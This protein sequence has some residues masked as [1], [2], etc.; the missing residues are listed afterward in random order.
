MQTSNWVSKNS[1]TKDAFANPKVQKAIFSNDTIK[2]NNN[3][4]VVDFGDNTYAVY[5]VI[6]HKNSV[7]ESLAN[8]RTS[9]I[10]ELKSQQ[11]MQLANKEAQDDITKLKGGKFSLN[12][13]GSN[14]VN[15][16]SQN[17]DIDPMTVKQIFSTSI[18]KLPAYTSGV[19]KL[20]QVVIYRI[21]KESINQSL[22]AQNKKLLEQYNANN[23]MVDFG[24][25]LASLRTKFSVSYKAERLTQNG[26]TNAPQQPQ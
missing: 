7:V 22:V 21:N 17:P 5:R 14:N 12:F 11:A 18:S 4:E 19:S 2:K 26:D 13:T 6:D 24:S 15:L 1:T 10:E 9:I 3:S 8:I 25:Y 23:A 20:S 16:L